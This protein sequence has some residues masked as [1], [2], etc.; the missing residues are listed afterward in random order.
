MLPLFGDDPIESDQNLLPAPMSESQR[1]T[2]RSLFESLGVETA[3]AQFD[4]VADLTG[5][6]IRSV[7]ELDGKTA[8]LLITRLTARAQTRGQA[9][10]GNSWADRE[11]DTWI[12]R[13]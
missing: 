9:A 4:F 13:L 8:Q 6:R 2:I 7:A 12:D 1:A 5:V 3:R 10:T 11:E